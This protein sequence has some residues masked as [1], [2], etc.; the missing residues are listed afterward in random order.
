MTQSQA[1]QAPLRAAVVGL[2]GGMGFARAFARS[3]NTQ[4]AA[5]CDVDEAG[6]GAAAQEF[7]DARRY[8]DFDG[9][10]ADPAVDLIAVCTPN[11]FHAPMAL[12]AL[13][14]G[15][16]V[17]VDQPMC[18][19]LHECEALVKTVSVTGL[20]LTVG[21]QTRFAPYYWRAH[22][23]VAAGRLGEIYYAESDY[24]H[25]IN[26]A[27]RVDGVWRWR[28]LAEHQHYPITGG[29]SHD[30]DMLR[31]FVGEVD[32][33]HCM[34][35]QK[36]VPHHPY[37]DFMLASLHFENGAI[38]KCA[39]HYG[40]VRD[41]VHAFYVF[42]TEGTLERSRHRDDPDRLYVKTP[43]PGKFEVRTFPEP[44]AAPD[45]RIALIDD[46]CA[47]VRSGGS[48]LIDVRDG[49][50]TTA[51]GLAA[52]ESWKTGRPVKPARF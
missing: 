30:V 48:P 42:G 13:E 36:T 5:L 45:P 38:G 46:L 8:A 1:A 17:I 10:L 6:L 43:E 20:A 41:F 39:S 9:L 25:D 11:T 23:H 3:A 49:A 28:G 18:L 27:I 40:P 22:E 14:S 12:A 24:I 29:A 2:G 44:A 7:P 52:V 51:V 37:P 19:S 32:E 31:W 4:V 34:A 33:V 21:F 15:K 16:H 35:T 47:A 26:Y 50:N